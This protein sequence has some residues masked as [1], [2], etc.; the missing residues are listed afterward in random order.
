V[1]QDVI[2]P[3]ATGAAF[4]PIEPGQYQLRL[5]LGDIKTSTAFDIQ[6][7]VAGKNI[8]RFYPN[9]KGEYSS[10][11][12]QAIAKEIF[13][14]PG[15]SFL[16]ADD[17]PEIHRFQWQ[18][19]DKVGFGYGVEEV[20]VAADRGWIYF[21]DGPNTDAR[22]LGRIKFSNRPREEQPQ[23]FHR[24]EDFKAEN[25][26]A[27]GQAKN[28]AMSNYE[29]DIRTKNKLYHWVVDRL[30]SDDLIILGTLFR[31]D[32][33]NALSDFK[34]KYNF[35]IDLGEARAVWFDVMDVNNDGNR[36][37]V[38]YK[39]ADRSQIY[40]VIDGYNGRVDT[41]Y[42]KS[43]DGDF[44]VNSTIAIHDLDVVQS[45]AIPDII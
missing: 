3:V 6:A 8:H 33:Y 36:D 26:F 4:T 27:M 7:G 38:L 20:W 42:T 28:V 41:P 2:V 18:Q 9:H 19:G 31:R 5:T 30:D 1:A 21:L 44:F 23:E 37:T 14:L 15:K 39:T 22:Y 11:G 10:K 12:A 45:T 16:R 24:L 29:H 43:I 13:I 25:L 17:S 32:P 35:V 40:G 34:L